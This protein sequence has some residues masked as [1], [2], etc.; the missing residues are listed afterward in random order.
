MMTLAAGGNPAAREILTI[1]GSGN[2]LQAADR[3]SSTHQTGTT[4]IDQ[5]DSSRVD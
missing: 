5:I 1:Q 4:L 3:P 2:D